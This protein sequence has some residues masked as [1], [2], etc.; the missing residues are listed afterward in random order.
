MLR[1]IL[2]N[3]SHENLKAGRIDALPPWD[4]ASDPAVM[5]T[6]RVWEDRTMKIATILLA[7]ALLAS[8]S[9]VQ[10]QSASSLGSGK[11]A[12]GDAVKVPRATVTTPARNAADTDRVID[13]E[14]KR[15][16]RM[17]TICTGC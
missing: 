16:D 13:D 7:G 3:F 6:C 4:Y 11:P 1:A 2:P 9:L 12:R 17:M 14:L 5:T 15:I 10:A 8:P